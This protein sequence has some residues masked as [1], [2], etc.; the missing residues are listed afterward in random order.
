[1]ANILPITPTL[2][3]TFKTCPRQ[4][5]AKYITKE[6][7]YTPNEAAE[8]GTRIHSAVEATL[9][10]G[11]PLTKEAAYMQPLV[12]WVLSEVA[13]GKELHVEKYLARNSQRK[14]C[15]WKDPDVKL[16][17]VA[18]V[19]LVDHV[20]KRNIII[21]WKSGKPKADNTQAYLLSECAWAFT[22]YRDC[23]CLWAYVNYGEL[24]K[25]EVIADYSTT[26]LFRDIGR[27]EIACQN[28]DFPTKK[29]GLCKAWCDVVTCPHNGKN[30]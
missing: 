21:D 1:M 29:N 23:L 30:V 24:I 15:A 26:A 10:N 28:N 16:R 17:G 9:K 7:T 13:A 4:Y 14:A 22:G 8:Y 3:N 6:V 20:N 18:D 11:V 5:Q 2:L 12:D 19:L 27:Y 25:E